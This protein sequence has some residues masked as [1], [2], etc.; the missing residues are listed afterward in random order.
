MRVRLAVE[1]RP[2]HHSIS[3][4]IIVI[5]NTITI[6]SSRGLQHGVG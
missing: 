6:G 3:F 2:V 1:A 5:T 4:A